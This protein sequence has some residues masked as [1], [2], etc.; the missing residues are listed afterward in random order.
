MPAA[1]KAKKVVDFTVVEKGEFEACLLGTAPIWLHAL[2]SKTQKELLFPTGRKNTAQKQ[3]HLKHD[4]LEEYRTSPYRNSDKA[5]A[6]YIEAI[7]AGVKFSM[8]QV[9][10]DLPDTGTSKAQLLRLLFAPQERIPVWGIP[11]L[12]MVPVRMADMN[13][14]P[15]IR[16]RAVIKTWATKI[17]IAFVKPV[18]RQEVVLKI[19]SA[20]GFM[21]GIGDWRA[22]KGNGNFG[23]F[24]IVKPT[25]KRFKYITKVGGRKAQ[26]EAMQTP[27][28][29]DDASR[30]LYTWFQREIVLRGF[31]EKLANRVSVIEE[32]EGPVPVIDPDTGK[33]IE[34]NGKPVD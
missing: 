25:D 23:T 24:E 8:A 2:N 4:P 12:G 20:A 26:I 28:F 32:A 16:T 33:L 14:T 5:A 1:K 18:L 15:D 22:G 34:L 9:A 17:R 19:L 3:A 27:D 6:T 13:R 29:Y 11:A 7:A 10:L 31:E 30:E 21:G